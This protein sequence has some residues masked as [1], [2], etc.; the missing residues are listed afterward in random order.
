VHLVNIVDVEVDKSRR[1][2]A[3]SLV[4]VHVSGP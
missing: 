2:D 4:E 3:G 1:L